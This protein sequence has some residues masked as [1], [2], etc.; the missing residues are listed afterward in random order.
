MLRSIYVIVKDKMVFTVHMCKIHV[1]YQMPKETKPQFAE[2]SLGA[3]ERIFVNRI[4]S[5][6]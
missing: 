1:L 5:P 6:V 2:L 3:T 4:S